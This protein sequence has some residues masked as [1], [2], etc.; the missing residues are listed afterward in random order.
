MMNSRVILIFKGREHKDTKLIMLR[1]TGMDI[2]LFDYLYL[3]IHTKHCYIITINMLIHPSDYLL[4][5]TLH[6]QLR[7]D[8]INRYGALN[9]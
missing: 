5:K 9:P 6:V 8:S 2:A 3:H 4:T 7:S 1:P